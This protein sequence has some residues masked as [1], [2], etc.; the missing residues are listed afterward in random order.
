MLN[1]E[2]VTSPFLPEITLPPAHGGADDFCRDSAIQLTAHGRALLNARI[3]TSEFLDILLENRSYADARRV[4]A[5]SLP[6][7]RALW[8]G[9]LCAWDVYRPDPPEKVANVL[10]SVVHFILEPTEEN[11]RATAARA[12]EIEPNGLAACLAMAAF[13][14][15][16]SLAPPGLPCVAPRPYLTGR[17][18]GVTVYLASVLHEPAR[19]KDRLRE[20]IA[21]G[22]DVSRGINLWTD[23]GAGETTEPGLILS[24][25]D[26]L[27]EE[28]VQVSCGPTRYPADAFDAV[29]ANLLTAELVR[30]SR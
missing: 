12:A 26:D 29:A 3:S 8:W 22:R 4:L 11:R 7:R 13:C 16:G 15:A 17:L 25:A 2:T 23:K 9:C 21:I 27:A 24:S 6:R 18:V 20:Y 14:S 28:T 30:V 5:H 10:Q 19:Y 1:L